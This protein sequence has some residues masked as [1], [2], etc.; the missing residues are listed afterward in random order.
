MESHS[1]GQNAGYFPR[2]LQTVLLALGSSEPPLFIRTLR[3]L[4]GNSYIWH[5]CVVIYKW[6][7]INRVPR[8]HQV[9]EAPTLRWTFEAGMREAAREALA[10]LRHE[11]DERMAYSQYR[12]FQSREEGAKAVVLPAGDHDRMGCFTNQVKLT[13]AL[14]RDLDEAIKEVKLLGEHEE[15]SS[16][17]IME[18]EAL[19]KKLREDAQRLEEE[20][21]TLE[22]MVESR[23]ELLMEITRETRL[24]HMGEDAMDEEEDRVAD[25]GGDAAT[26]PA[27]TPPPPAPPTATPEEINDDDPVEMIPEQEAPLPHEVILADAEPKMP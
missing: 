17:K 3:L 6:P 24:D 16:Q 15:E 20:K 27:A 23:D 26:P 11:V 7:M 19:C 5:V 2:T 10:I 4:R 1:D 25:D 12:H 8:I 13:R 14:V 22:G 18:L 9:V 21:A